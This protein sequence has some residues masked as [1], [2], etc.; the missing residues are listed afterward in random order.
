MNFD[1]MFESVRDAVL[2]NEELWV[3]CDF[4]CTT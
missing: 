4:K 3:F 2:N 1:L